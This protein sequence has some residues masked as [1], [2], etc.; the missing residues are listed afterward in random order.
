MIWTN[1]TMRKEVTKNIYHR[2]TQIIEASTRSEAQ[3]WQDD[4]SFECEE[5]T[6]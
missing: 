5:T 6:I 4:V 3:A 2:W 1:I